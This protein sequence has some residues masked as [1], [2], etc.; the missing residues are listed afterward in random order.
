[1][2]FVAI[3]FETANERRV[4]ACAVGVCVVSGNRM[5]TKSY[6]IRPPEMRFSPYNIAIHGITPEMVQ[7]APTFRDIYPEIREYLSAPSI[8]AHYAPFDQGV[9]NA[10]A[11]QYRV[12]VPRGLQCTCDLSRTFLPGL[13]SHKLPEVCACLGIA[14]NHH[15]AGSDAE[16]CA[17]IV[18]AAGERTGA[19]SHPQA[20]NPVYELAKEIIRD[21][22]VSLDEA[23]SLLGLIDSNKIVSLG[24]GQSIQIDVKALQMKLLLET[25]LH[26]N[27]VTNSESDTICRIL[28]EMFFG[29]DAQSSTAKESITGA[30]RIQEAEPF[31]FKDKTFCITGD[32]AFGDREVVTKVTERLGGTV[33]SGVSKKVDYLLIGGLLN[34]MGTKWAKA[35]ELAAAGHRVRVVPEQRWSLEVAKAGIAT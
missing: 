11:M 28:T 3:D 9:L 2:D 30:P 24:Q 25:V 13:A 23:R 21:G 1:M 12:P 33:K 16:A 35:A 18:L 34:P 15:D 20:K 22:T 8:W 4:S 29:H 32:F 10:L 31:G 5:E 17:R 19:S 6:L 27:E 14:L 26:D 7:S